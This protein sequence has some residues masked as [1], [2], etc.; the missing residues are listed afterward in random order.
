LQGI[1]EYGGGLIIYS[2]GN[3]VFDFDA[4]D[5]DQ[6]GLPSSLS[7]ILR[8]RLGRE[9]VRGHDFLPVRIGEEDGRP[10]LVSGEEAQPVEDRMERLSAAL[11]GD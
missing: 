3:F 9:G 10:R 2:L 11:S 1:E 5:Y 4:T 6:P 8:V 7:L